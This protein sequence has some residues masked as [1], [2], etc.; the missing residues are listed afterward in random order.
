MND[1]RAWSLDFALR[2]RRLAPLW[3]KVRR[4]FLLS[5]TLCMRDGTALCSDA[6]NVP[7]RKGYSILTKYIIRNMLTRPELGQ[8][9][10]AWTHRRRLHEAQV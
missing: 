6:M 8:V 4:P 3:K 9:F 5:Q 1:G 10:L 2:G 7:A